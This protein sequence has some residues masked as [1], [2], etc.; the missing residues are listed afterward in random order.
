[1]LNSL[2]K[3]FDLLVYT[4]AM[5]HAS[6]LAGPSSIPRKYN[7]DPRVL[8]FF[9]LSATI[10]DSFTV[11]YSDPESSSMCGKIFQ[12]SSSKSSPCNDNSMSQS[13]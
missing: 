7:V 8:E 3:P 2:E 5:A 13:S 9:D 6:L 4:E 12:Q 10:D 1:M 11:D